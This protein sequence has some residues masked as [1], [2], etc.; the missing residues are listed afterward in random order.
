M[1]KKKKINDSKNNNSISRDVNPLSKVLVHVYDKRKF[2]A[3][4]ENGFLG[5][6]RID[7]RSDFDLRSI[8]PGRYLFFLFLNK[9]LMN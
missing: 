9:K 4:T 6:V 3:G 8:S 2:K 5:Y 1:E 7:L